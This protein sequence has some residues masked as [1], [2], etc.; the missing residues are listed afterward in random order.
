MGPF[1]RKHLPGQTCT[2]LLGGETLLHTSEAKAALH[3]FGIRALPN[4]P[5]ESPDL[6]PQENVWPWIE[7]RLRRDGRLAS[8]E[9]FKRGLVGIAKRYPPEGPVA[10]FPKRLRECVALK[11][12]MTS[13]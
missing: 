9:K 12:G 8:F 2:V 11:G 1:V 10:S 13:H 5:S 7:E 6:R 4:W 3:A